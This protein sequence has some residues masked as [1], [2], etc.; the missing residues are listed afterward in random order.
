MIKTPLKKQ[1]RSHKTLILFL[2]LMILS[3]YLVYCVVFPR[4]DVW[5][6][7]ITVLSAFSCSIL[8]CTIA[9]LVDPGYIKKDPNLDFMDL[10][11][12]FE[13]NCLCPECEV[14][15][16]PR[17]RHCNICGRCVDRFDHHCPWINNCV[18]V[19]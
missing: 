2:T 4:V 7:K 19:K 5:G 15:R 11:E 12:Q 18:G 10:L 16:T 6:A 17:S 13:P 9:W 3:F 14:I 8:F 1:K